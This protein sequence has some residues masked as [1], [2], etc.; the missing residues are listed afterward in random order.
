MHLTNTDLLNEPFPVQYLNG[1]I[2]R[3]KKEIF[4]SNI[5]QFSELFQFSYIQ[6]NPKK[7]K[8]NFRLAL[9]LNLYHLTWVIQTTIEVLLAK[10]KRRDEH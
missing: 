2:S 4:T 9:V 6:N 10:G 1:T 7:Q 3:P 8:K 5:F